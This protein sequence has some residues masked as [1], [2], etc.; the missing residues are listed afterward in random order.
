MLTIGE[1]SQATRL[2][3]KALRIYHDEGLLVP[4]RIDAVNGYRH[5]GDASFRRA[6]AIVILR[7]LGF[8]IAEMKDIFSRC[9]DDDELESF[10]RRRLENVERELA[11]MQDVRGRIRLYA[12]NGR[13]E[14]MKKNLEI[15][16]IDVD[17]MWVCGIRYVGRY[18]GI[19]ERFAELFRKAGRYCAGKPFAMYYDCEHKEEAD[20]EASVPVRKEVTIPGITCRK[21]GGGRFVSIVHRGPYDAIGTAYKALFEYLEERGLAAGGPIRELYLK[22]PGMIFPRDPKNF[23]TEIMV[24]AEGHIR[25]S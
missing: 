13:D 4:E 1:F 11:R 20:I 2:T 14:S 18:D 24:P 21:L 22:G 25:K 9:S 17:D 16:E 19:G 8:S 15:R 7:D 12:E 3:V 23:V 6:E 5:Y 10:F